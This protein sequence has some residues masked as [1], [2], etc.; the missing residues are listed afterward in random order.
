MS[1]SK[2]PVANS[3]NVKNVGHNEENNT[4]YVEFNGGA[5]IYEDVPVQDGRIIAA[6]AGM[7]QIST[8]QLVNRF[9]KQP[10]LKFQKV[11]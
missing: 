4:V 2:I 1:F 7:D 6:T 5:Y 10:K 8:G 9:L 11:T 3:S